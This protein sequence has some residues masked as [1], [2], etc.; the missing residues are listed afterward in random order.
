VCTLYVNYSFIL[1]DNVNAD[2]L[3]FAQV[4]TE[5]CAEFACKL[6]TC[7]IV[8]CLVVLRKRN[9]KFVTANWLPEI[10]RH[11]KVKDGVQI[12]VT[13]T[14]VS[15]FTCLWAERRRNHGSIPSRNIDLS[16]CHRVQTG[17]EPLPALYSVDN[18]HKAA[19][20]EN[21]PLTFV[22]CRD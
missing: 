4:V 13:S 11:S 3:L 7:T 20:V 12:R 17:F 2:V 15:M 18:R 22:Y 6:V 5:S 1:Y 16:V 10:I 14:S 21:W 8:T 9:L 19:R